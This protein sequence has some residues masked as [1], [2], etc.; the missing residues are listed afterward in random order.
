MGYIVSLVV[1]HNAYPIA[2]EQ[3]AGTLI[4]P[5]QGIEGS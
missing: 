4:M 2:K 5:L 1:T 3:R